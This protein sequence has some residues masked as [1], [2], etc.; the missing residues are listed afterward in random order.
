MNK[1]NPRYGDE[2]TAEDMQTIQKN[3]TTQA[4]KRDCP[5]QPKTK[6]NIKM[7][8]WDLPQNDKVLHHRSPALRLLIKSVHNL[9]E[10]TTIFYQACA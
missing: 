1:T 2:P 5:K 9:A 7:S 10:Y 6:G 3:D 4:K 8:S